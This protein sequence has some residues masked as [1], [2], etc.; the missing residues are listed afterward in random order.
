MKHN[1]TLLVCLAAAALAGCSSSVLESKKIDYKSE[2]KQVKPLEIPPDLTS[3]NASDRYA[4]P[5]SSSANYSDYNQAKPAAGA[6]SPAV[7]PATAKA[8]IE[9]AGSQR[10]LVVEAPTE[11]VWPVV[12]E[13]WQE[14]GFIIVSENAETGIMAEISSRSLDLRNGATLGNTNGTATLISNAK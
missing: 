7:L 4:V 11:Q 6:A 13:F 8:H 5:D 2:S 10:W 12:R 9:R 3:P 1:S 14:M